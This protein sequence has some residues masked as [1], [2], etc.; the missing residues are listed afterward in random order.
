MK[1]I[2]LF[3]AL[4]S[5]AITSCRNDSSS[6][7]DEISL[8]TQNSYDDAAALKFLNDNYLDNKGNIVAFSDTDTSDDNKPKLSSMNPVTLPSGVIYI[9]I[10]DAQP[11]NG[12]NIG[13]TDKIRIMQNSNTY[14]ATKGTDNVI[15]FDSK[16]IFKNTISGTG[17][18]EVDPAYYYVKEDVL[19]SDA[20]K[21]KTRA[22]FEIEGFQEALKNFQSF[23]IPDSDDY[24]LQ[25]IIIVPSRAAFARDAHYPY[26]SYSFKNRSF[27]FNF[28]IYKTDAR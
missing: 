17:T 22:Y 4:S 23:E 1:K 7:S 24:H 3:L 11:V 16:Y 2:F 6:N 5:L 19:T 13:T 21:D 27:I 18:P 20:Y 10:A 25:G 14:V 28:Q 9:K 12:K 8:E 26:T 15:K